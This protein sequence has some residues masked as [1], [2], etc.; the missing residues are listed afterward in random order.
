MSK[1][2]HHNPCS[3]GKIK[4]IY[5]KKCRSCSKLGTKNPNYKH[6]KTDK[7]MCKR[8]NKHICD[9]AIYC[10]KCEKFVHKTKLIKSLLKIINHRHHLDLNTKNNKKNNIWVLPKGK[11][12]LFHRFAYHYLLEIFGIKEI[13]KY[14]KWFSR[15]YFKKSLERE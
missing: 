14:K 8:C 5:A 10:N 1:D 2:Y 3:C 6:G 4:Y 9:A 7:N 15:K 11:H 12:Q 13:L